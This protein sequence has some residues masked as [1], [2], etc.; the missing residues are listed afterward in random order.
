LITSAFV[1]ASAQIVTGPVAAFS[2]AAP[3]AG[4]FAALL[5]PPAEPN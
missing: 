2:A 3:A 1:P 5:E 4:G